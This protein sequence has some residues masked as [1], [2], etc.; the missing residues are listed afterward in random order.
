M[1]EV[2]KDDIHTKEREKKTYVMN[3][4]N[5]WWDSEVSRTVAGIL[6][7]L[8]EGMFSLVLGL[9]TEYK[10][11]TLTHSA[12]ISLS[13]SC[14]S[15]VARCITGPLLYDRIDDQ[16]VDV[17]YE[18]QDMSISAD[19]GLHY[20]IFHH[21]T[22]GLELESFS[23]FT[24]LVPYL[25]NNGIDVLYIVNLKWLYTD[26]DEFRYSLIKEARHILIHVARRHTSVVPV[27]ILEEHISLQYE[28]YCIF[29]LVL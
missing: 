18:L 22:I 1:L 2:F 6:P 25:T 9:K 15:I 12:E 10:Y 11:N 27:S 29:L 4:I 19:S 26:M 28:G 3:E 8:R 24:R 21:L 16:D 20:E 7:T 14:P 13:A 23:S 5:K 17:C